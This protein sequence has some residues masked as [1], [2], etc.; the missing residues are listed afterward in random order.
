MTSPIDDRS[1]KSDGDRLDTDEL[2]ARLLRRSGALRGDVPSGA[3]LEVEALA[4]WSEGTLLPRE[5]VD[6]EAH[7]AQCAR[8]RAILA[9]LTDALSEQSAAPVAIPWWKRGLN[10]GWLVPATAAAALAIWLALP[11]SSPGPVEVGQQAAA[12]P[13]EEVAPG[14]RFAP[15][16]PEATPSAAPPAD[17]AAARREQATTTEPA[18]AK[19]APAP[20][21]DAR[22]DAQAEPAAANAG[23]AP[24]RARAETFNQQE[25]LAAAAPSAAA[26]A[27][28]A[29]ASL[30]ESP[31]PLVVTSINSTHTW[32]VIDGRIEFSADAGTTWV[33]Q[34][35]GVPPV[36]AGSSPGAGVCWLV[37]SSGVVLVTVDGEGWIERPLPE[38]LDLLGV[39]AADR[40]QATVTAS[41]GRRF[42]TVDGGLTWAPSP[43]QEF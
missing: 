29:A 9:T 10:P 19:A 27:A 6:T 20:A 38:R 17:A 21:D 23:A 3:C 36:A 8:C 15:A 35:T 25:R 28:D 18:L 2:V 16:A 31:A 37:G 43:P 5:R 14:G 22:A 30:A 4:A 42:R 26:P 32:R 41:S 11:G 40:L 13:A 12:P 34:R 7:L 24:A 1:G 39:L 33:V